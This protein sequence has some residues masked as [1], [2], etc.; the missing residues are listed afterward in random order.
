MF[1]E[2]NREEMAQL[3]R[4]SLKTKQDYVLLAQ[5]AG[6]SVQEM[7]E[8]M[9]QWLELDWPERV[10][11]KKKGMMAATEERTTV[12]SSGKNEGGLKLRGLSS[13]EKQ[14]I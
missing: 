12:E 11:Q 8:E 6:K 3:K 5:L 2:H 9:C 14:E 10:Q 1:V 7:Q 4:K 13:G